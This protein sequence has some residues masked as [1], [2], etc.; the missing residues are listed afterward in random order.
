MMPVARASISIAA[1]R[2]RVWNAFVD[3]KVIERYMPVA[4]FS[5]D[6]VEGGQMTWRFEWLGRPAEVRGTVVRV[7]PQRA[8]GYRYSR[9]IFRAGASAQPAERQR[10]VTIELFDEGAGTRI[11]LS[12]ENNATGQ[13]LA[14]A[15]GG[16]RLALNNLKALLESGS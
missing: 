1:P 4:D 2:G 7:D 14:H 8:L 3:P 10:V 12:E 6:W 5:A 13:E 11:A 15:E 16:W 9:P